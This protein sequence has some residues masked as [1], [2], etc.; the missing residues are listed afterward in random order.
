M[1]WQQWVE[2]WETVKALRGRNGRV[3]IIHNGD[4]IDGN[5]HRTVE[6]VTPN[7]EEQERIH[8]EAMDWVI[9]FLRL[10]PSNGDRMY[11]VAGTE[12]HVLAGSSAEERIARDFAHLVPPAVAPS[13][14]SDGRYLRHH[15]LAKISEVPFDVAHHNGGVGMRAWTKSNPLRQ[16]LLSL[17]FQALEY[18]LTL[19]R[20]WIRSHHHR[21]IHDRIRRERGVID[22]FVTPAFQLKTHFGHKV[23]NLELASIG[24]LIVEIDGDT[25]KWH[26]PRISYPSQET[27]DQVWETV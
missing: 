10:K 8:I 15:L 2:A 22:G 16:R 18:N 1:I 26:C 3:V 21:F 5:H 6:L 27:Q 4:A 20:F 23:A 12:A 24:M 17:Y 13:A 19:P 7:T 11:Y 9:R 25:V 14:N